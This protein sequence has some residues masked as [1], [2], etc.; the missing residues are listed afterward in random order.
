[1]KMA[2]KTKRPQRLRSN[3]PGMRSTRQTDLARY[4]CPNRTRLATT[5]GRPTEMILLSF[6]AVLYTVSFGFLTAPCS[7]EAQQPTEKN[8]PDTPSKQETEEQKTPETKGKEETHETVDQAAGES[9]ERKKEPETTPGDMNENPNEEE[10][11]E[12]QAVPDEETI[13]ETDVGSSDSEATVES[14]VSDDEDLFAQMGAF[15]DDA[16]EKNA[17]TETTRI[18]G[19]RLH[20][21][22]ENQLTGL[23]LR[24][25]ERNDR[26]S[27]YDYT[28]LRIDV[29]A[30]LPKDVQVR[31]DVVG[32]LYVGETHFDLRDLIPKQTFDNLIDRDARWTALI[33]SG[34]LT[35]DLEDKLY[36]DNAYLKIPVGPL[37]L[38][39]GKQPLEQ[40]AGYVWNPTDVFIEKEMFDPTYEKEGVI[41]LRAILELGENASIDMAVAPQGKFKNRPVGVKFEKW[42][43]GGR[44]RLRLGPLSFGPAV[45]LTRV[46][47][48][49]LEGSIDPIIQ[50]ATSGGNPEDAM[51]VVDARRV[52]TGGEAVLD[53]EGIRLWAEGAY[54]FVDD[55]DG[56]PDDWL[57]LSTGFEYFFTFETHL[58]AE[59]FHYGAGPEQTDGSYS[60]NDWMSVLATELRVLGRNLIF[61][62]VDHPVAD[63]WTVGLWSIA[64]F[65]DVSAT[66]AA[67][68]R[69]EFMQDGE[70]WLL[71]AA[72]AGEPEDFL[73]SAVGQGWLR[74]KV[75]F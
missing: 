30:D 55:K 54:N 70:L 38:S 42:T 3:N 14:D 73:S 50:T 27:P 39:V 29:D 66:L 12:E 6:T 67:D 37:L 44:A 35:Y 22:L 20:G 52:M 13:S 23:W 59:Y 32:Q 8:Q 16:D 45:Y 64:S 31:S 26:V 21:S 69:W 74:A 57:E 7:T 48:T 1:M 60:I 25:P 47:R 41:S 46:E 62:S 11:A 24:R 75:F 68:V 10:P 61:V 15:T 18:I 56:A 63:F 65:S 5:I 17:S 4:T 40:G 2:K 36:I 43:A 49:D 33:E 53:V 34:E 28:R 58:M 51:R 71:L 19:A 72:S 9:Q